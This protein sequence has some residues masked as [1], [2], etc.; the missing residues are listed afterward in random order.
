MIPLNVLCIYLNG[1]STDWAT[2]VML[3]EKLLR[4]FD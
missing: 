1:E 4:H 2:V 3:A